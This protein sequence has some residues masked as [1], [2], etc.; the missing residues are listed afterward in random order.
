VF[1]VVHA[2][3]LRPLPYP[4][5]DQL[6]MI[7]EKR[8]AEGV[9][10]NVVSPAD[11]LDWARL[12]RSFDAIAG[13]A[14]GTGDLTGGG[15]PVQVA[16]VAVSAGFFD[17]LRVTPLWGRLFKPEDEIPG[18][19][20]VVV[21]SHQLWQQ[22]YGSSPEV[23]GKTIM[24][25]DVPHQVIGVLGSDF[26]VPANAARVGSSG[27]DVDI[28]VPL[29]LLGGKVPPARASHF[30]SVFARLKPGV[31]LE[32]ARSEMDAIG[33]QLEKQYPTES[34]G[35]GAHV[36]SLRDEIVGPVRTGLLVLT[37]SVAFVLLIACTN[38]ANL[39]IARSASRRRELAV[40]SAVGAGRA[41][42]IRQSLT[43]SVVLALISGGLG[44]FVAWGGLR[45]LVAQTPPAIRGVGLD[46]AGLDPTVLLFTI[47]VCLLTGVVAGV[48]PAWQLSREDPSEPLREGG[49]SP[50]GLRKGVRFAL[51]AAQVS[52]TSLLLVGAGLMLR[53]FEEVLS[54][55]SGIETTDRVTT[56]IV[57]PRSRYANADALRRARRDIEARL[58]G[59]SGVQAVGATNNLPLTPTDSR[60]GIGVDGYQRGEA[61]PPTRA[62]VRIATPG[63]FRAV[64]IT[65][66]SGRTFTD[67][68]N[69][70]ASPVI[71]INETMARRYWPN[72]S[73][74]GGRIQFGGAEEPWR[75][76]VGII[77]DVRHWGLDAPVNPEL[78]LPYDQ[79]PSSTLSFVI[80]ASI[81]AA[82]LIPEVRRLVQE[83]DR[84]LPL[85][86]TRTMDEVAA[87][88]V[89]ARRWSAVLLGAFAMLA[90]VLAAVGIYGVMSQLVSTRTGEIGIRLTLGAQPGVLLR[91][92]LGEGVLHA[93]AGLAVGLAASV[94]LMD[95][96]RSMLYDISPTDPTTL[97]T[98]AVALLIV[99]TAACAV[100][101]IR[102]MR[103]DPVTALRQD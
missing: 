102:A 81:S 12:N 88:S 13:F 3:V 62:H 47:G 11:Y 83:A 71:V 51:I 95:G 86:Q 74:V 39:L 101:A 85:A 61:D 43:E 65:T 15:D 94:L 58:A 35:H 82:A 97:A 52:L 6:V 40:R 28:W 91:Q 33:Q 22:R 55:P 41:R 29:V 27:E 75:E 38:V 77:E 49:R 64:G 10:R 63:Y 54:E 31:S 93:S 103:I 37:L 21:M 36:V 76:V 78:Y 17:V 89:A 19:H 20:R 72:K 57:L 73:A 80:H 60:R 66:T 79:Q 42:L 87:R 18:Q 56:T 2:V 25:S 99:A 32:A 26:E 67:A 7:W 48:I 23:I 96:L 14:D 30:M 16:Y 68:D 4:D 50:V 53:S 84:D 34:R 69:G 100:P 92:I 90:L 46:R 45:I 70:T 59:I 8:P 5:P 24:L 1:S 9:M 98:T 44:L